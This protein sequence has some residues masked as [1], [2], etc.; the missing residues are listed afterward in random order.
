MKSNVDTGLLLIRIA[1]GIMFLI[2]GLDKFG[3]IDITGAFFSTLGLGIFWVYL[4]VAVEIVGA[5]LMLVGIGT[6][7]AGVALALTMIAA[8]VMTAMSDGSIPGYEFDLTL[9][10]SA[11]AISL[12]G[13][14]AYVLMKKK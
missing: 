4:F 10:L 9:F 3:D 5:I 13:P 11:L 1:L 8:A 6:G 7:W 2:D 12:A 14:G